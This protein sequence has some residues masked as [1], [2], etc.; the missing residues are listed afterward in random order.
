MKS[1]YRYRTTKPQNGH[2]SFQLHEAAQVLHFNEVWHGEKGWEIVADILVDTQKPLE[3]RYFFVCTGGQNLTFLGDYPEAYLLQVHA[4]GEKGYVSFI[5]ETT[6]LSDEERERG[7]ADW[8]KLNRSRPP[9][10]ELGAAQRSAGK[11]EWD[12]PRGHLRTA[13][14]AA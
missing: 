6:H 5:F 2:F 3:R 1:I 9:R 14:G 11:S 8:A 7:A 10:E 12:K 13:G 4:A